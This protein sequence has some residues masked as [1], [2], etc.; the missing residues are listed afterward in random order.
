VKDS[1]LQNW[2][3]QKHGLED[4]GA[5][6]VSAYVLVFFWMNFLLFV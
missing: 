2:P 6:N 3:K 1:E 4:I 5:G